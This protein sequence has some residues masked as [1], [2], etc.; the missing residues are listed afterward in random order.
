[1]AGGMVRVFTIRRFLWY[2]PLTV[3]S[4]VDL[5][6]GAETGSPAIE[7]AV[8]GA[9]SAAGNENTAAVGAVTCRVPRRNSEGLTSRS[10]GVTKSATASAVIVSAVT[11]MLAVISGC[12]AIA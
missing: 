10:C 8:L 9:V 11:S 6:P 12:F 5:G 1:M 4:T 7:A 3:D 2:S